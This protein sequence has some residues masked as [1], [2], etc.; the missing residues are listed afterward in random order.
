M[1]APVSTPTR[2]TALLVAA[3]E[4]DHDAFAALVQP[5]RAGLLTHCYRMLGSVQDAE[6]ALQ[7]TL[8]RAYRASG[9]FEARSSV[10]TWL[11]SIAT[12][13]C[14]TVIDR[15]QRRPAPVDHR[16]AATPWRDIG[17]L[18]RDG[19]W[20]EP[21]SDGACQSGAP[22]ALYDE[23]ESVELAFIA[24][25]QHLTPRQRAVL[26]LCDVLGFSAREAAETLH[27]TTASVTSAL[28]RARLAAEER[29]PER[30]Q[31]ETLR[32]LGDKRVTELVEAYMDA[33][34]REDV[35]AVVAMLT[36]DATFAMPPL[37]TRFSGREAIGAF[38]ADGPLSG[39][40][41]WR[42]LRARAN[43]QEALGYYVWDPAEALYLPLALNVLTLR[44]SLI[45]GVTAFLTRSPRVGDADALDRLPQ[46]PIDP[47][48]SRIAF[49]EMGLPAFVD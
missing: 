40:W 47:T 12:N 36:H 29:L 19:C 37:A 44:D 16:I 8:L 5:L 25:V 32:S 48:L 18:A 3:S 26:I 49:D 46:I 27:T 22:A 45:G 34:Q 33:W 6:E 23:L 4:G 41:R 14:L 21:F 28:Q 9:K 35:G 10:T 15:R 43:G 24:A 13:A 38:L 20:I 7:E 17:E 11:H 42:A 2:E 31:Q 30:S 39:R 1:H